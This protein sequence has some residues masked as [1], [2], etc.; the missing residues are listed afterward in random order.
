MGAM[1]TCGTKRR[2]TC[3]SAMVA[4]LTCICRRACKQGCPS[5]RSTSGSGQVAKAAEALLPGATGKRHRRQTQPLAAGQR[6]WR[7]D[8]LAWWTAPGKWPQIDR[9]K[10][11]Q[12][13]VPHTDRRQV[14]Q[15]SLQ[16]VTILPNMATGRGPRSMTTEWMTVGPCGSWRGRGGGR[17]RA[18]T[19]RIKTVG[20]RRFHLRF[21]MVVPGAW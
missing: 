17:G 5:G 11:A 15:E 7:A 12:R 8:C 10:G 16:L 13:P 2:A 9:A 18:T 3:Q 21:A 6:S 19:L 4:T 1:T 14:V 20:L